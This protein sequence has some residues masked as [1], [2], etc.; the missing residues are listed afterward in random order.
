MNK[1]DEIK[2]DV[3][4]SIDDDLIEKHSQKRYELTMKPRK[5]RKKLVAWLSA[6]ASLMLIF[7]ILMAVILPALTKQ[8]P[9]YQGMTVSGEFPTSQSAN[10]ESILPDFAPVNLSLTEPTY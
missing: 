9:V 2:I 8:V 4:S 1:K 7:G 10:A 3:L 6:A 5:K